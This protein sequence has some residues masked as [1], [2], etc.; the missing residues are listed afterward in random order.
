MWKTNKGA[1]LLIAGVVLIS[2]FAYYSYATDVFQSFKTEEKAAPAALL[3]VGSK[4]V[5]AVTSYTV[6]DDTDD[7]V[8]FTLAL[9][10]KG[11]IESARVEDAVKNEASAKQKEFSGLL[12]ARLQGKKLSELT[13]IDK[14]GKSSLTTQAFNKVIEELKSQ[15]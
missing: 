12:T 5:S 10:R 11:I 13:T 3:N 2:I 14:V 15:M 4:E 9:D 1:F 8:R 6:P 7:V